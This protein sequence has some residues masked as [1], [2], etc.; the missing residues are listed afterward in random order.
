M[1][2]TFLHDAHQDWVKRE[3][4]LMRPAFLS[5]PEYDQLLVRVGTSKYSIVAMGQ[6]GE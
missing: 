6:F 4:D 5:Q 1:M 3:L 2:P